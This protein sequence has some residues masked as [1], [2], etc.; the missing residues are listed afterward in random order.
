MSQKIILFISWQGGMGHITRDL[1]I[2]NEIHRQNPEWELHW[3]THPIATMLLEN[4]GEKVLPESRLSAD[5]HRIAESFYRDFQL[6]L[7]KYILETRKAYKDNVELF[8]QVIRE[9]TYDLIIGD[10]SYEVLWAM[11]K[12]QIQNHPPFIMMH[13]FIGI[14]SVKKNLFAKLFVNIRNRYWLKIPNLQ[15]VTQFFIGELEDVPNKVFGFGLPNRQEWARKH[16]RILGNVVRFNP[17]HYTDKPKVRENLG[18]GSD[19]LV[20][21]ALGGSIAGYEMLTLCGR[22]FPLVRKTI[23]NLKMVFSCGPSLDLKSLDVPEDIEVKSYVPDLYDHFAA[24]DLAIV[25]G[26]GTSTMELIALN[27]PFLYFPLEAQFDQQINI[28]G[29]LERLGAGVKMR[30]FQTAPESLA[31][32]ILANLG[33]EVVYPPV[34]IDGAKKAVQYI[35]ELIE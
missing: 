35:S 27:R 28:A 18:Y 33:K 7:I 29:R 34:P 6:S 21:C 2:A 19:P 31:E 11:C 25:V 20:V 9:K 10:E 12:G 13:D 23:P 32:Q 5:Y 30:Y 15:E 4:A 14:D 24:S 3:L 1:A 22:A 17:A 16:C 8:N 26:G